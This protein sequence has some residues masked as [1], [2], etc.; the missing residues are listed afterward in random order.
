MAWNPSPE[1]AVARDAAKRLN[2]A[3][4]CI[5]FWVTDDQHVGMATYGRTREL[6]KAAGELGREAFEALKAADSTE[7]RRESDWQESDDGLMAQYRRR[8]P[9]KSTPLHQ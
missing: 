6:C 2:N 9:V 8:Y 5:V 1:V 7:P 3:P 4:M